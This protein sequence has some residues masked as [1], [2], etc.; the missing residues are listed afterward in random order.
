MA[1]RD[2]NRSIYD[3][4]DDWDYIEEEAKKEKQIAR[5]S[6]RS[7]KYNITELEDANETCDSRGYY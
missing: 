5:R 3:D 7:Q 1:K 4:W 2:K 6:M